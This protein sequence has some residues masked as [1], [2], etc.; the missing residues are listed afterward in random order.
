MI[1]TEQSVYCT[2]LCKTTDLLRMEIALLTTMFSLAI[3]ATTTLS[4]FEMYYPYSRCLFSLT[5][6]FLTLSYCIASFSEFFLSFA[7]LHEIFPLSLQDG[8]VKEVSSTSLN[9]ILFLPAGEPLVLASRQQ[10][11]KTMECIK[12]STLPFMK[13]QNNSQSA[14]QCLKQ[15]MGR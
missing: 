7:H 14:H 1:K 8:P 4:F 6:C 10:H 9:Q 12:Y 15:D 2:C 3:Q 11:T 13:M 5:M